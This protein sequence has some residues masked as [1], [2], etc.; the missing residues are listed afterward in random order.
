MSLETA[1]LS[2]LEWSP[3]GVVLYDP[4]SKT[5]T[6][7]RSVSDVAG[8]ARNKVVIAVS[9]RASFVRLTRLPDIAK[10]EMGKVLALQLGKILPVEPNEV[11]YDFVML[12]DRTSEG[13]LVL[14]AAVRTDTLKA[15][16]DEVDRNGL[17]VDRVVPVALASIQIAKDRG[18][19]SG[20]VI[21]QDGGSYTIDIID[22]GGLKASRTVSPSDSLDTEVKRTFASAFVAEGR[23]LSYGNVPMVGAESTGEEELEVLSRSGFDFHIELP[24][25]RAKRAEKAVQQKKSLA[26]LLWVAALGVGAVVFDIRSEAY[27]KI[28][29]TEKVWKNKLAAA[30]DTRDKA[31]TVAKH[32][33]AQKDNLSTAFEPSQPLGDVVTVLTNLAPS[34]LWLTGVSAER[35][36]PLTLRGTA[37]N[38]ASVT[39]YVSSLG[40]QSRMRDVKLVFAN[41]GLVETTPVVNFSISAHVVGNLPLADDKAAKAGKS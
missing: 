32:L 24:E 25:I 10:P 1:G 34:Q 3:D 36:K 11:A 26:L 19:E 2:I 5:S 39:S 30:K 13:R 14:V 4:V 23:V 8:A 29:K 17:A 16:L 37:L 20:A 38:S 9:R 21:G 33:R 15:I 28:A 22:E 40:K 12:D 31:E 6:K 7:G 18:L 41:N 27:D 35:G